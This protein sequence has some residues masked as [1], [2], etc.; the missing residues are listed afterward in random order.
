MEQELGLIGIVKHFH[1]LADPRILLKSRHHLLDV[2]VIAICGVICGADTWTQIEEFGKA[3]HEWLKSFLRLPHGIPSHDTF[4]RLFALLDARVF[5]RC[6]Q[7]WIQSIFQLTQGEVIAIDGKTL[8]R[9]FDKA[10]HKSPLH[11]I[12]A[13]ATANGVLLGQHKVDEKHNEITEIPELLKILDLKGCIVTIDAMGCQKKIAEAICQQGADYVL[14][15]KDNQES[16]KNKIASLFE[17]GQKKQFESMV[18]GH[19]EYLEKDHSRI[20]KRSCYTLPLMYLYAFKEKWLGLQTVALVESRVDQGGVVTVEKR[21]YIS[22]LPLDAKVIAQAV[23]QH[24]AIENS[25]H[26]CLDVAFREDECRVRIGHAAENFS[27]LRKIALMSLKKETTI[28]GG[29]KTK[30]LRA[31]WDNQYLLKVL[32][33]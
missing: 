30:R 26:W 24:W 23:R 32:Q 4:G 7:S 31:G 13:W 10:N 18:Y 2:I 28:K 6:F 5:Q 14:A 1:D 20:E 33:T 8:R 9:S 15:V 27:L 12:H 19:Y 25:L 21:Y 29:L 11:M 16:L 17:I 22:S 3:R